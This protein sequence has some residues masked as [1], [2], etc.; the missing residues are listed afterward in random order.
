[1]ATLEKLRKR[2][3]L[4]LSVVIG[5]A[6]LAFVLGD[7]LKS[8]SSIFRRSKMQVAEI[9][10]DPVPIQEYQQRLDKLTKFY[11]NQMGRTSLDDQ[12]MARIRENTWQDILQEY[13]L[14][15][16]YEELGIAVSEDE[17]FEMIKGNNPHP[18]VRQLFTNP[19]TGE[20]NRNALMGFLR[21][22]DKGLTAEQK[23]YWLYIE[24]QIVKQTKRTKFFSLVNKGFY[25]T[26][27]EAKQHIIEKQKRANGEFVIKKY[28]D[29]PDTAVTYSQGDLSAY[30][31]KH[32]E[33]YKREQP[34]RAIE[35]VLFE[36]TPSALDDSTTK[37]R[38]VDIK[39]DFKK[40]EDNK[41][42]VSVNSDKEFDND[43]KK[44]ETYSDTLEN[45]LK[46]A[47][48]GDVFGPYKEDGAY[49]LGK[50]TGV[51]DLPDSVRA[52]QIVIPVN[53]QNAEQSKAL[54]DSLKEE[55]V[56]G[57]ADFEDLATKH[58]ADRQTVAK[59]GDMGWFAD[60]KYPDFISDSC[61]FGEIGEIFLVRSGMGYHIIELMDKG[62]KYTK[63]QVA[64][65]VQE[66]VPSKETEQEK[67]TK[68]AR[69]AGENTTLQQMRKAAK[70]MGI[71]VREAN[72]LIPM[73][74]II[75]GVQNARPVVKWAYQAEVGQVRDEVFEI[76]NYYLI[77]GLKDIKPK[78]Y[79]PLEEV[80]DQ[81]KMQVLNNKKADKIIN[82]INNI[83]YEDIVGLASE[84]GVPVKPANNITFSSYSLPGVGMEPKAISALVTLPPNKLSPPIEGKNGVLVVHVKS[85]Q[86]IQPGQD[87]G[88]QKSTLMNK[89]SKSAGYRAY[90]ALEEKAD[91]E[92]YRANFY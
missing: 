63:Y 61:F 6:L 54:A 1:M 8:G 87:Y 39:K 67:Y 76:D 40:T 65:I 51:K 47:S 74:R 86:D 16:L 60:D 89:L 2:S 29:L 11:E 72:N 57:N 10:G 91:V 84:L 4:L 41:R 68:A 20:F 34:A 43:Y 46:N 9:A 80:E 79:I 44:P 23:Q 42:F 77:A 28:S 88:L 32:K 18:M 59:G 24:N 37:A 38:V 13:V 71:T 58:S 14:D 78:G 85:V 12:T 50:L 73:Q 35:Y 64:M 66:V 7:L 82:E 69:F 17:L 49:K 92:D 26:S 5:M 22:L 52:R 90:K 27:Y 75:P 36:L 83:S 45:F 33:E 30:Y 62:P 19:Q 56:A 81:V 31:K 53:R 15:D 25:V 21:N 70:E 3:G 55:L 48:I